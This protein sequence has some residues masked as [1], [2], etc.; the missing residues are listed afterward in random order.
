LVTTWNF[1]YHTN[2]TIFSLSLD[3]D[4]IYASRGTFGAFMSFK[5]DITSPIS[6]PSEDLKFVG[7]S[8][9]WGQSNLVNTSNSPFTIPLQP[10]LLNRS[11]TVPV[12][13]EFI[14]KIENIRLS[15]QEIVFK[16]FLYGIC[17]ITEIPSKEELHFIPQQTLQRM[18][19]R[20]VTLQA[21]DER[22]SISRD[23]WSGLLRDMQY[24]SFRLVELPLVELKARSKE[25]WDEVLKQFDSIQQRER[26]GDYEV[27]VQESRKLLE[28]IVITFK[29]KFGLDFGN[30]KELGKKLESMKSQI[31]EKIPGAGE[32]EQFNAYMKLLFSLNEIARS[33]HHIQESTPTILGNLRQQASFCLMLTS[34]VVSSGARIMDWNVSEQS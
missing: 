33:Y 25:A 29:R 18:L 6:L 11:V 10:I 32:K 23:K 19:G 34:M 13:D 20:M 1:Q 26:V 4:S 21:S 5:F 3:P 27:C 15:G 8:I 31:E 24:E 22:L 7:G 17:H 28:Q 9:E 2:T 12:A 14:K 30:S 16:V